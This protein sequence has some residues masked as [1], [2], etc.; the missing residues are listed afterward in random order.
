MIRSKCPPSVVVYP[1]FCF[2]SLFSFLKIGKI[3]DTDTP[4]CHIPFSLLFFLPNLIH[5]THFL[6]QNSV[7][8]PKFPPFYVTHFQNRSYNFFYVKNVSLFSLSLHCL[9]TLLSPRFVLDLSSLQP[10]CFPSIHVPIYGM[11]IA[12]LS[13]YQPSVT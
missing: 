4:V 10:L 6:P 1:N 12:A 9:R 7:A 8:H 13:P 11:A 3:T 2:S 5:S